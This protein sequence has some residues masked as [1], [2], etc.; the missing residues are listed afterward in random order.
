MLNMKNLYI[1]SIVG[2]ILFIT[3]CAKDENPEPTYNPNLTLLKSESK[4]LRNQEVVFQLFDDERD[5]TESTTFYVNETPIAGNIFS[6][7]NTGKYKVRGEYMD[8]STSANDD[9]NSFEVFIPV[10]KVL[11]EG[12]TG[13]WCPPCILLDYKMNNA[14]DSIV[15]VVGVKL[16]IGQR[17]P[18]VIPETREL[19]EYFGVFGVPWGVIDRSFQWE[20]YSLPQL[21]LDQLRPFAGVDTNLSIKIASKLEQNK[22]DLDISLISEE[23]ISEAALIVFLL[24]DG[25]VYEQANIDNEDPNS[26]YYNLGDPIPDFIHND[27]LR[28]SLT[29]ILG[30]EIPETPSLIEYKRNFLFIVPQEF[31]AENLKIVATV[32][33]ADGTVINTQSSK[34]NS[35]KD[36]E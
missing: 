2:F 17:D 34:I 13:T 8:I 3:A 23:Q 10:K 31:N 21:P 5:V 16:H 7:P 25:L 24:E 14:Y 36:Y 32:I 28:M 15:D 27:V 12:F 26:P 20:Y 29:D 33:G 9:R 18:F 19:Y 1:I 22:I 4:I 11:I 30:D 6:S 35:V